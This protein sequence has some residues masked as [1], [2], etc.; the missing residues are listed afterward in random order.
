[1]DALGIQLKKIR[2]ELIK[3]L[4]K[5]IITNLKGYRILYLISYL[6]FSI[7]NLRK[8]PDLGEE[9]DV[10]FV[11]DE[12]NR[13]WILEAICREI[14]NYFTGKFTFSYGNYFLVIGF[15][16]SLE[17]Y[18]CLLQKYTFFLTTLISQSP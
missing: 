10:V 4:I 13:G 14:S 7:K 1:M 18:L 6:I 9:Y 12:G 11:I 2:E 15:S 5:I 16:I 17:I 8:N 3:P